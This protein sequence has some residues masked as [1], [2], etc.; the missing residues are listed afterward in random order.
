MSHR[1][2][3][4]VLLEDLAGRLLASF[5]GADDEWPWPE[6]VATYENALLAQALIEGGEWLADRRM[7]EQGLGTLEFLLA[8]Q[9]A[10][11]GYVELVG[12][13][14]LVADRATCRP[15]STSNRSM[16]LPWSRPAGWPGG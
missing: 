10:P 4:P 12:Q 6:P 13:P 11:A 2:R 15:A 3:P 7:V 16:P 5:D 14:G 8:G 9:I 1:P